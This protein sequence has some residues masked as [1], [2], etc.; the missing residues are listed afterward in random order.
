MTGSGGTVRE[1]GVQSRRGRPGTV[2]PQKRPDPA[3][4]PG[5]NVWQAIAIVALLAAT[6][7]WT[8]VAV[9]AL[10][11][12]TS[13]AVDTPAASDDPNAVDASVP[14]V[15]DSHTAPEL[16]A[17]LPTNLSDTPLLLQS[18][19]GDVYLTDDSWSTSI[20]SF[21]TSSGKTKP[22]FH[23]AQ[24]YDPNQ[25]L[26]GTVL[27][28]TVTG[29][30]PAAIRDALLAAWKGDFPDLKV[31][32][33]TLGGKEVTKGDFGSDAA[34]TFM[35]LKDGAVY[36]IETSD[37]AIATAAVAAIDHPG[38]SSAPATSATPSGAAPATSTSPAP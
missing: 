29:V 27:V 14:P 28:Y 6:A 25:A 26:D 22:D 1:R 33:M 2:E 13:A 9:I 17:L 19:T 23:V 32:T 15:A 21:L 12:A 7:G 11:P 18:W 34:A 36:D 38:A 20:S 8:T 16:E 4:R 31:S 35:Y 3:P 37:E 30:E 10:R 5:T 24:A